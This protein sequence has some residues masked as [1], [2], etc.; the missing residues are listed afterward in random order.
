MTKSEEYNLHFSTYEFNSTIIPRVGC[1][2]INGTTKNLEIASF[3]E[4]NG[5]RLTQQI[6]DDIVSLNLDLNLPFEGYNIWGG[7]QDESVEI[8]SPPFRAVFNTTGK[9]LE[10]PITDFLQILHEWKAFLQDIPNPHWL[11]NR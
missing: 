10:I 1:R 8:K 4:P 2:L 7:N 3:L 5:I 9:P 6:I 11:S